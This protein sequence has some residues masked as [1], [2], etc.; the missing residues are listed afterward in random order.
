MV[1]SSL[2]NPF[3]LS[4]SDFLARMLESD[5]AE[6]LGSLFEEAGVAGFTI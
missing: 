2:T 4:S 5:K 1:L 3:K 6:N